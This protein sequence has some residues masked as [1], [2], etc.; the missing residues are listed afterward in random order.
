M[1][2]ELMLLLMLGQHLSN[3]TV[4]HMAHDHNFKS[5]R[6]IINYLHR[7][8]LQFWKLLTNKSVC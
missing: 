1:A 8:R 4:V 7:F 2:L 5:G 6:L 3:L